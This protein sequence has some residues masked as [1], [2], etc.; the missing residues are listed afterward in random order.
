MSGGPLP[1]PLL[2]L[3][4]PS[5]KA[6]LLEPPLELLLEPPPEL[7]PLLLDPP[8]SPRSNPGG[9]EPPHAAIAPTKP[10]IQIRI[11]GLRAPAI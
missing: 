9:L 5:P 6:P 10:R 7:P 1:P 2:L 3:L 4:P 8:P 11:T